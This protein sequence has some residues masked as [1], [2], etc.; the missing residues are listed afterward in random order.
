MGSILFKKTLPHLVALATFLLLNVAYFY[1]QLSGKV[2][3]Q[4]DVLGATGMQREANA[5]KEE[6]G[7]F[8]LWTNAMF[9]GMPTYQIGGYHITNL[10]EKTRPLVKLFFGDPIGVFIL[11]NISCY[12]LFLV[13]GVNPWLSMVGALAFG[14]VTN[15]FVLWDTGHTNKLNVL[16]TCAM[17]AAGTISVYKNR[18]YLLGGALFAFGFGMNVYY[19][20]PQMTYYL[21]LAMLIYVG[22]LIVEAAKNKD[23]KPFLMGSLALTIGGILAVG[24]STARLWTTYEYSKDTM[25]GDPILKTVSNTEAQ[26][27]SETE[28]LAYNYAMQWSAGY[29]D[30]VNVL[31]PR[32]VGGS[33]RERVG[34]NS[35]LYKSLTSRGAQLPR[36]FQAPMYWG[37][38]GSTSGTYYVGA[39]ICML[40]LLGAQ[41]VKGPVKWWLVGAVILTFMLALGK[42]LDFF[43]Q[44]MF[45]NLPL[46]S[47][48][49]APSSILGLTSLFFT[50]LGTLGLHEVVKMP[51]K[52]KKELLKPLYIATG[53]VGGICL[54]FG[55]L[56][57]SLFDFAGVSDA[58]Y[59]QA[60]YDVGAIV[61]DRKALLRNDSFRSLAFI[62]AAAGLIWAYVN[63]KLKSLYLILAVG[64]L[65]VLDLWMVGQRYL[66]AAD[67]VTPNQVQANFQ[68][69]AVDTQILNIEK[70]RGDYRVF[71]MSID[72]FQSASTSY[73][74]NTVGGYHPAKLQRYQDMI[75]YYIGQG[76]QGVLNMLNTKYFITQQGQLQQNPNA[77]GTAW[78]VESI[79]KADSPQAEIDA[80]GTTDLQNEAIVLDSEFN[81]YI[82]SFDPQKNGTIALTDYKPNHLTYNTNASSEQLAVFSEVWYG[83]DKGWD[84]YIDGQPAD[85]VRA[86]YILRA[87]KIPS[88]QH[89]VEFKFQPQSFIVGDTISMASSCL[90]LLLLFGLLGKMGFDYYKELEQME[91]EVVVKKVTKPLPK[92]TSKVKKKSK[93]RR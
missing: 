38:M 25:R 84:A 55:V 90:I 11:A 77:Y 22:G 8:T 44:P 83:P 79:K 74:H 54:L 5:F 66:K 33:S 28:G 2:L 63:D 13:L 85:F 58:Q 31:I 50:I 14:F 6:T 41:L 93:K 1:P 15:N 68:P 23:F 59:Q 3:Q 82:G 12:I 45:N 7:D 36:D 34:T 43:N 87:M 76:N 32:S 24:A 92:T 80:V 35:E 52:R 26:T 65:T 71:D 88:G 47:K 49:R 9:G 73:F 37:A 69:R 39:I 10:I 56:G 78:F 67:F 4:S 21:F 86:N 19:N 29:M 20:H 27:S 70:S 81:S 57:G 48:F 72:V 60:G 89:K 62:L 75:D 91:P 46:L 30:L 51:A 40:F 16:A 64:V 61:A 53:V 42:N 17:V 18:N